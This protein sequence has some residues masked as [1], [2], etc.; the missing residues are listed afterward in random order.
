MLLGSSAG[1]CS[2]WDL[3][4]SAPPLA[5]A[6]LF[7]LSSTGSTHVAGGAGART[8]PDGAGSGEDRASGAVAGWVPQRVVPLV[9][10]R[11]REAPMG[12]V[13]FTRLASPASSQGRLAHL[14]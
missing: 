12:Q 11:G 1:A 9:F 13:S 4:I 2:L 14:L 3:G 7:A 6:D 10:D 8:T 5:A